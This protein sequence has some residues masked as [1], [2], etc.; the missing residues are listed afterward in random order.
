MRKAVIIGVA[1]LALISGG[2]SANAA[3]DMSN[4]C[5]RHTWV[6]R[7]MRYTAEARSRVLRLASCASFHFWPHHADLLVAIASRE[8]GLDPF[9]ANPTSSARGL[10]QHILSYWAGRAAAYLRR[11]W[12]KVWPVPWWNARAQTIVT[13]RMMRATGGACPNWC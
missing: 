12:F 7:S 6:P 2:D 5:H 4:P 8:S 13:V 10:Y 1:A 9:A 3:G 11:S